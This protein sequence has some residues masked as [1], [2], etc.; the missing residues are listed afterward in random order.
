MQQRKIQEQELEREKLFN[1][2]YKTST[3][4][5]AAKQSKKKQEYIPIPPEKR[6]PIFIQQDFAGN[7][8]NKIHHEHQNKGRPDYSKYNMTPD[9]YNDEIYESCE[10]LCSDSIDPELINE[11]SDTTVPAKSSKSKACKYLFSFLTM[12]ITKFA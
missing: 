9:T 2:L 11:K 1:Y 10:S 7:R 5:F 3:T 6:K 4:S 12:L 8:H